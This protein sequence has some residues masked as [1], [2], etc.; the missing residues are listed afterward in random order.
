MKNLVIIGGGAS[1]ASILFNVIN[2]LKNTFIQPL[3]IVIIEKSKQVGP[4]LAYGSVDDFHILNYPADAMSPVENYPHHFVDWLSENQSVWKPYFPTYHLQGNRFPPRALYGFYLNRLIESLKNSTDDS[5]IKISLINDEAMSIK[6]LGN[7]EY[8][9]FFDHA[10][11]IIADYLVICPGLFPATN[12]RQF[13]GYPQYIHNPWPAKQLQQIPEDASVCILGTRLT[14]VDVALSL[15]HQ[16]HQGSVIMASRTG[17]LPSAVGKTKQGYKFRYLTE[18]AIDGLIQKSQ[19][20]LKNLMDLFWKELEYTTGSPIDTNKIL[21]PKPS[22]YSWLEKQLK[23]AKSD[24]ENVWQSMLKAL[25]LKVPKLW[26]KLSNADKSEFLNKYFSTFMVY[27]SPFPIQNAEKLLSFLKSKKF[28]IISDIN[29]IEYDNDSSSF[30][31]KTNQTE[32]NVDYVINAAAA[33]SDIRQSNIPLLMNIFNQGLF[34]I[35]PHGGIEVDFET[36]AAIDKSGKTIKNLF[37]TGNFT[38]GV[39]LSPDNQGQ[40]LNQVVRVVNSLTHLIKSNQSINRYQFFGA[41]QPIEQER[42]STLQLSMQ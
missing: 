30:K 35:N 1:G 29:G 17:L 6:M 14:A 26:Q 39:F 37:A 38:R 23:Q 18:Q 3:H 2:R 12:Y 5:P 24:K 41:Q 15:Y 27:F 25:Y 40:L 21:H 42:K 7:G 9:V 28:Q 10:S 13:I 20:S 31:I 22:A 32:Y 8:K 33:G 4:G 34:K 36:S 19:F 16:N 11:P